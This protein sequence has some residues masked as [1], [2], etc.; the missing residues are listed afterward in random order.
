MLEY[1]T[2]ANWAS[3]CL[4]SPRTGN[5]ACSEALNAFASGA[6]RETETPR[7]LQL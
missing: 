4:T 6:L 5:W 2:A 1:T 3:R 7:A